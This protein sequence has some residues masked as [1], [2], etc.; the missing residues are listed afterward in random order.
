MRR[1]IKSGACG[2]ARRGE[3]G[4]IAIIVALTL[5]VLIGFAGLALDLGKLYVA[6]SELSNAADACALAAARDLTGALPLVTAE[7]AGITVGAA[8]RVLLQS[9]N[10]A[11]ATN[12]NVTFSKLF[13]GPY[14][15]QNQF[16]AGDVPGIGFVRCTV[17]R[18]NISNWFMQVVSAALGRSTVSATA[19]AS[20]TQAQTTCALPMYVCQPPAPATINKYDWL[21]SKTGPTVPAP[22]DKIKGNFGWLDLTGGGANGLAGLFSGAGYCQVP[23][24]TTLNTKP[25]LSNSVPAAYNTRFGIYAGGQYKTPADGP[26]DFTG[27]AYT[28]NWLLAS[29][30]QQ[31]SFTDFLTQRLKFTPYQGDAAAGISTTDGNASP[32]PNSNY[33]QGADRRLAIIPVVSNC[34]SVTGASTPVTV[35]SWACV[36]LLHPMTTNATNDPTIVQYLGSASDA[37]TPCATQGIPGS[38]A[39]AWGPKVPVLVQ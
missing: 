30:T 39:I 12:S 10:V 31:G 13:S 6:K 19:V 35:A 16:G 24:S 2:A 26:S 20:T 29:N 37:G 5:V 15:T 9:E 28:N 25:G 8:N 14:L 21:C 11:L 3:R 36:L 33:K 38:T 22:C 4:V 1:V 18:A 32:P 27:Y 23:T 34:S 7:A 17:N